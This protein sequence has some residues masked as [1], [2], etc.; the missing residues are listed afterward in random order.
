MPADQY[1]LEALWHV[2]VV[3]NPVTTLIVEA[4]LEEHKISPSHI[5]CLSERGF[6]VTGCR[7]VVYK[8]LDRLTDC[9]KAGWIIGLGKE[10][11]RVSREIAHL[12]QGQRFI[13]LKANLRDPL[14]H[15]LHLSKQCVGVYY[16]EEGSASH[17]PWKQQRSHWSGLRV[18]GIWAATL[19]I[20]G[21]QLAGLRLSEALLVEGRK[22]LGHLALSRNAF[23][24][25]KPITLVSPSKTSE[26]SFDAVFLGDPCVEVGY[27][28]RTE[29]ERWLVAVAAD[30]R[31]RDIKI[32]GVRV[33]PSERIFSL[34]KYKK[35]FMAAVPGSLIVEAY[36]HPVDMIHP[37]S[38]CP[39]YQMGSSA[40]IY[41][42]DNGF[43][44]ISM[45][46]VPAQEIPSHKL[47]HLNET[48]QL[49]DAYVDCW[50]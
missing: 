38:G 40:A 41:G 8:D 22:I 1:K 17:L 48:S 46:L 11:A 10:A 2:V 49:L 44:I 34:G 27:F 15:V 18:R 45:K 26:T 36:P 28:E 29:R 37:Q 14:E 31:S 47:R 6:Q 25:R 5:I 24:G 39:L 42:K 50:L 23:P 7:A 16:L 12:T 32:L 9:G 35:F 30:L 4:W 43:R 13:L 3:V 33:H 21:K 19:C 20:L